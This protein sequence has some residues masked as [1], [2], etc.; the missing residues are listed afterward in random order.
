MT[1]KDALE[2]LI[3]GEKLINKRGA[4]VFIKNSELRMCSPNKD[5]V[6]MTETL[7]HDFKTW[8]AAAHNEQ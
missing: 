6:Y 5:F 7:I 8:R 2:C 1:A 4:V 3:K